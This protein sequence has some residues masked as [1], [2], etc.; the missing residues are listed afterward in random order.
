M[1]LLLNGR[2]ALLAFLFF[3]IPGFPK[4]YLCFIL[5]L[6]QMPLRV[7]LIIC[8]IGRHAWD[9]LVDAAGGKCL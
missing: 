1:I 8:S 4:D 2:A 3:L 9:L 5:G 6:S 7:F